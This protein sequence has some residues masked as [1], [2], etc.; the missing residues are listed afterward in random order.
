MPAVLCR[1]LVPGLVAAA[2][3]PAGAEQCQV[4]ACQQPSRGESLLLQVAAARGARRSKAKPLSQALF[5]MLQGAPQ[6]ADSWAGE[7]ICGIATNMLDGNQAGMASFCSMQLS[8]WWNWNPAP[9]NPYAAGCA[10]DAFVPMLWGMRDDN[11]RL[12]W[13]AGQGHNVLMGYNEPDLWAP[14]AFPGGDYLAS[15]SF[16]PTFHCGSSALAENWRQIVMYY[17]ASNPYGVVVS[18]AMADPEEGAASAGDY[19]RCDASPQTPA[20]HMNWCAG[21]LRCFKASVIG[22]DCGGVNCWDAI[23]V[24]QFHAYVYTSAALIEKVQAWERVWADD[25]EGLN[26]RTKKSLW[27]TEFSRAGVTDPA[28]PDGSGRAFMQEAI[29]YLRASP[30]VSG[31]SWFS[32]TNRTFASFTIGDKEPETDFWASDLIDEAGQITRLGEKYGSLCGR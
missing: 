26:G 30:Y 22:L 21:W 32:Q 4:G 1:L 14:P 28:D 27:L 20:D 12:A 15:G 11:G 13:E 9:R 8:F 7:G 16:A 29:A 24:L 3:S 31:W 6:G 23:D 19:S 2:A 5:G 17:K 10:G 18:P 25:L